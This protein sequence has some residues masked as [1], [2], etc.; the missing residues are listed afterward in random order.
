MQCEFVGSFYHLDQIPRDNSPQVA[1][2]GRSNVGKSSLLNRLVGRKKMAKVS[3]A[4][5]KTRALNFFRINDAFYLVDLPGYG[6]AKVSKSIRNSWGKLIEDF[7]NKST[8]LAGLVLLLDCRREPSGDDARMLAYLA[9]KKMPVLIALTKAD[10][11]SQARLTDKVHA[12][13]SDLGISVIP[14]SAVTGRGKSELIA[15]VRHLTG[16]QQK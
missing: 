4:P 9:R 10:K 15:A 11:L 6:Y 2:A 1:I 12:I 8:H 5:G 7:L 13:E 3:K 16:S 14:V